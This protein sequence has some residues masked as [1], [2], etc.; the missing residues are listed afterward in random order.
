MQKNPFKMKYAPHFGMFQN[1]AGNDLVDQIKFAHDE[2]FRAWEDN[3]M[4]DRS[5]ADQERVSKA[6]SQVGMEMG[7]FVACMDIAW[8]PSLATGKQEWTDKFVTDCKASVEVAKRMNAKWMTVV[9]G[10]IEPRLDYGYQAVNVCEALKRGAEILEPHGMVMVIEV[11]N[12]RDHPGLFLNKVSQG[13][14]LCK[15]VGSPACKVLFDMYHAQIHEGNIIPN[16]DAAWTE[17]GYYQ[18]GDNP[19]R[20][21]PTSGEVNYKNIFSHLNKK[22]FTGIL[23]MEH[24]NSKPGKDGERAVIDAYRSSDNF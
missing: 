1:S 18:I 3:G 16:I 10:M 23:G 20:N 11:L 5:I 9:P 22:G 13:F 4:R 6:M 15:A 21:E 12:F 14:Q 8:V 19:G 17:I 7:I 2:G 24:G